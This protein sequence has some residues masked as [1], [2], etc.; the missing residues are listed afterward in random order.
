MSTTQDELLTLWHLEHRARIER[1]V[2]SRTRDPEFAADVVSEAFVRLHHRMTA[3]WTPDDPAAWLT[4]VALNLVASEGRH[5]QVVQRVAPRLIAQEL[6]GPPDEEVI[7][8]DLLQRVRDALS[9]L[10]IEDRSLVLA[11]AD[12]A[13]GAV[14][15][16]DH[17]CT[18]G[19]A[20]VRL[21]RARR[22]LRDAVAE[23]A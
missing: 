18:A 19:G 4:R 16:A 14:L 22:R 23:P 8:R 15:G 10:S 5:R 20:R 7:G 1:I 11:A 6:S 3:G 13:T 21:H 17:G 9:A 2:V 12:G